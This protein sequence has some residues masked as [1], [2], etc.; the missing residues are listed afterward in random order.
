[1]NPSGLNL[2]YF[3]THHGF[4][5]ATRSAAVM[6]ALAHRLPQ[7]QFHIFSKLPEFLFD[8]VIPNRYRLYPTTTDVGLV[9]QSAL[10]VDFKASLAALSDFYPLAE[11]Y[12]AELAQQVKQLHCE[13][14]LCDISPLGIAV[15]EAAGIPS[16]LI[17]NF[18][19]HWIYRDFLA[20]E[21]G[22][23]PFIEEL[24]RLSAKATHHIQTQPISEPTP[25]A[26][27]VAPVARAIRK[28]RM[29]TR[30]ALK[31]DRDR[32]MVLITMG[33]FGQNLAFSD[34]LAAMSDL[35]FVVPGESLSA[36]NI[37]CPNPSHNLYHPDLIAACDLVVGKIG[38]STFAEV[39]HAGIPYAYIPRTNFSE[40]AIIERF[41][42]EHMPHVR[43][44]EERFLDGSWLESL[45]DWL[46]IPAVARPAHNGADQIADHLGH[47]LS[48]PTLD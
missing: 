32:P 19:F 11:A 26:L 27:T 47:L 12:I 22:F 1:M 24:Q 28:N 2:A 31:I 30:A 18:T 13:M 9:Q 44:T 43:L 3:I 40:S 48:I 15:A 20:R 39:Y 42:V 41:I 33:G 45:G 10:E 37:F 46:Q 16:V 29:E 8:Q 4:G 25:T 21:P 36:D 17:E 23:A 35:L 14:I 38:Y 34:R 5:H 7:A 6:T